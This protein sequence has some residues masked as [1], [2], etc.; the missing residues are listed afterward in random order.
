V[1]IG[2]VYYSCTYNVALPREVA[3]EEPTG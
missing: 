3:T 1:V 2:G